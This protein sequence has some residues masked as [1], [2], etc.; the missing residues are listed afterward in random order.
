MYDDVVE[1]AIR[2]AYEPLPANL[3]IG[4]YPTF[5]GVK[6]VYHPDAGT[7]PLEVLAECRGCQRLVRVGGQ[8]E[9]GTLSLMDT[10]SH[11]GGRGVGANHRRCDEYVP[12]TVF[13]VLEHPLEFEEGAL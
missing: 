5:G 3:P 4:Q 12:H 10:G 2:S 11:I 1:A 6:L 9:G 13:A 8:E 7:M